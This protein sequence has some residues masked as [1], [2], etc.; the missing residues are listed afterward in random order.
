MWMWNEGV[1]LIKWETFFVCL[2]VE[3]KTANVSSNI[4]ESADVMCVS[5]ICIYLVETIFIQQ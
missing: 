1:P 5:F 4:L 2:Q 3:E